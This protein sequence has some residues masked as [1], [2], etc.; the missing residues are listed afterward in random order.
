MK[1][2]LHFFPLFISRKKTTL[3]SNPEFERSSMVKCCRTGLVGIP[4][5]KDTS[6]SFQAGQC[7]WRQ[8]PFLLWNGTLFCKKFS[9]CIWSSLLLCVGKQKKI[10]NCL[11]TFHTLTLHLVLSSDCSFTEWIEWLLFNQLHHPLSVKLTSLSKGLSKRFKGG[12]KS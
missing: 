4:F 6:V 11:V 9:S 10:P 8:S 7:G 1:C 12:G 2:A 3:S 5:Y